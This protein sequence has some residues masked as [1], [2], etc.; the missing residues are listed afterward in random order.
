MLRIRPVAAVVLTVLVLLGTDAGLRAQGLTATRADSGDA[1]V[2][3]LVA[4]I[5]ALRSEMSAAARNQLR[6]QCCSA[7]SRCRNSGSRISTSS[8]RTPPPR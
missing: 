5:R 4:E 6:A 8:G 3:A 1:A 2:A 7:A